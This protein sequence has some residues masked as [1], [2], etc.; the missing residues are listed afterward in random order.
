MF[1]KD[2]NGTIDATALKSALLDSKISVSPKHIEIL[3]S[4][5]DKTGESKGID[6]DDFIK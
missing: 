5:Y 3:V 4:K 2:R 6:Y 1:D